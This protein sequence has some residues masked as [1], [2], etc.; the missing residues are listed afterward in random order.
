MCVHVCCVHVCGVC[1]MCMHVCMCVSC[2]CI[3]VY[4]HACVSCACLC[5]CV[6][7][8]HA[9]ACICVCMCRARVL[10]SCGLSCFPLLP[11]VW[12]SRSSL[13]PP[14]GLPALPCSKH[15]L[16]TSVSRACPK[17]ACTIRLGTFSGSRGVSISACTRPIK[18]SL[19]LCS[20]LTL[21]ACGCHGG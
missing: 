3:C 11:T 17:C 1:V 10:S 5:V 15:A 12:L 19:P 8:T 20:L 9:H 6:C 4:A 16:S 18:E 14:G 2:A 7:C 21:L 13:R